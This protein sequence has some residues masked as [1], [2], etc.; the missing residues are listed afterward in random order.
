MLATKPMINVK[1]N[2]RT[3]PEPNHTSSIA[4]IIVVTLESIIAGKARPY[5]LFIA[6]RIDLPNKPVIKVE[7]SSFQD[8]TDVPRCTSIGNGDAV[9]H[10]VEHLLGV[11]EFAK[12]FSRPLTESSAPQQSTGDHPERRRSRLPVP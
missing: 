1:P 4:A 8:N 6:V 7:P 5:P 3:G 11:V 12:H 9:I 10:T 2:P